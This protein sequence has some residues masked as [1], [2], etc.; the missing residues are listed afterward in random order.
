MANTALNRSVV[1]LL[2][3]KS[4]GA[5]VYGDVVVI[6]T[7]TASAFTT[8]TTAGYATTGIG[9]IIEPNGIANDA[10]GL[11]ATSGWVPK[12]NLNTAATLGQYIKTHTVAG[13]GTPHSTL[14]SGDF[15]YALEASATPKAI[16][17]GGPSGGG[18]S[19]S[20]GDKG[21]ITI[22]ASGATYTIDNDVVTYAKM[23]NAS[24]TARILA[25]KTAGAGDY[26]ECTLSEVLDLVGSAAQGDILYRGASDWTRLAA[27]TNGHYLKTQGAAANP[28]W[29]AVSGGSP[30]HFNI[31]TFTAPSDTGYSWDNQG[32]ATLTDNTSHLV[33]A[34]GS[35]GGASLHVR[36][37]TAP[38]TPYVITA[39]L[40]SNFYV[41]T[42][43]NPQAGLVFRESGSG[44]I[45]I[46]GPAV[47]GGGAYY[48]LMAWTS[49]SSFSSSTFQYKIPGMQC[50]VAW[51]R[52]ADD[53]SNKK[54][55]VSNDSVNWQEVFSHGR[56]TFLTADQIGFG[57]RTDTGVITALW[58]WVVT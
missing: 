13:Q 58:H 54:F 20:D 14:A 15:A 26:E 46:F 47:F 22:S 38:A 34:C 40:M 16:L 36:Y 55:S 35:D 37:K 51:L 53:G 30:G 12:I 10:V 11:V 43:T 17:F 27:G 18:G 31:T 45:Q 33:L 19:V 48:Q 23:Q 2:T 42:G 32:S 7:G 8:T 24:A 3:N 56:T 21:D 39:V 50:A 1:A 28:T 57:I 9:V 41:D 25:R 4:G 49:S 44:K 6:S 29:A 5:L 52:I